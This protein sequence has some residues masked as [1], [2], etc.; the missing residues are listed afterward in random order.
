MK[1]YNEEKTEIL[2][3]YDLSIGYL[4]PSELILAHHEAVEADEGEFHWEV[5][6]KTIPEDYWTYRRVWDREPTPAIPAW[7]EVEYIQVYV[8]YTAEELLNIKRE[9]RE[10]LLEAFDKYKTN[11][12]YGVKAETNEK[13]AE[14]LEWYRQLLD[15]I[16]S[17]FDQIPNE[18]KYYLKE[19]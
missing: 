4:R 9:K 13:K 11:V 1:V 12:S 15:L 2:E 7:D 3:N 19:E 18:I 10:A 6:D 14:I 17:A 8:L 16:D 5:E